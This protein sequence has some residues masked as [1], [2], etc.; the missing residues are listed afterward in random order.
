MQGVRDKFRKAGAWSWA[1]SLL[2]GFGQRGLT[3]VPLFGVV[4]NPGD[5]NVSPIDN[6][7]E[8]PK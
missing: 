5:P 4:G 1:L 6:T 7:A 3:K 8:A 2:A